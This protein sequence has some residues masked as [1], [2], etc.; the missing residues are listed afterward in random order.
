MTKI[1][2]LIGLLKSSWEWSG[3]FSRGQYIIILFILFLL[4]ISI[5]FLMIITEQPYMSNS[6]NS[7]LGEFG[8]LAIPL[9][10]LSVV[11]LFVGNWLVFLTGVG[12]TIRRFH[13][14]DM[15]GW[16]VLLMIIIGVG[17]TAYW[18]SLALSILYLALLIF[19][20]GIFCLVFGKPKY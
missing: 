8:V 18:E 12:A 3:R 4:R 2:G 20:G 14:M 10:L 13:D 17:V 5:T 16:N 1:D 11:F 9:V 7:L 15:S 6:I 19:L